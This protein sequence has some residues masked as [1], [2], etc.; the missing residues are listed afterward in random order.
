ME[1]RNRRKSECLRQESK[2]ILKEKELN[3]EISSEMEAED[4]NWLYLYLYENILNYSVVLCT[5]FNLALYQNQPSSHGQVLQRQIFSTIFICL[6]NIIFMINDDSSVNNHILSW[7]NLEREAT[8]GQSCLYG[9]EQI[10]PSSFI[11]QTLNYLDEAYFP[12]EEGM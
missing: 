4:N 7:V 6:F 2:M 12:M 11:E 9:F 1:A 5:P 10:G 8:M 3:Y